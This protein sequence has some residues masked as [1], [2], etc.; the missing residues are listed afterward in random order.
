EEYWNIGAALFAQGRSTFT[1]KLSQIGDDKAVV[2]NGEKASGARLDLETARYKVAKLTRKEQKRN[3]P[4]PYTTSKLQ[5]DGTSYLHFGTK[6]TMQV[7]QALYEGIDLK[8]DGGPVGLI[9]YMRTDS[10]RISD[11]AIR[12]VRVEIE[13]LYGAASVPAQP[14]IYKSKKNA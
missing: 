14:N 3:A 9:T 7:A 1:A 2:D 13:K 8:R 11:D 12:E 10:T 6:R 4:A 5:Q